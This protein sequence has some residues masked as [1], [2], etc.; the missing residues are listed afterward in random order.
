MKATP[1][2][3]LNRKILFA[4]LLVAFFFC[5]RVSAVK[6]DTGITST[7]I[8]TNG[9]GNGKGQ[10]IGSDGFSRFVFVDDD[11][12][13][14]DL[15]YVRC[16]DA[17]CTNPVKTTVQSGVG[18]MYPGS[19][20]L[21]LGPDGFARILYVKSGYSL[22][23]YTCHD[24]DCS[25]TGPTATT[26]HQIADGTNRPGYYGAEITIGPDGFPRIAYYDGAYNS[27]NANH[28]VRCSDAECASFVDT[29]VGGEN[30]WRFAG[31]SLTM[32]SDGYARI[33]YPQSDNT[34][35]YVRCTDQDC[36]TSPVITQIANNPGDRGVVV[37]MGSDGFARIVYLN[38]DNTLH[39]V[40]CFNDDC[41][42][43]SD[44]MVTT[45]AS[46]NVMDGVGLTIRTGDFA[47][48]AY[49]GFINPHYLHLVTCTNITCSTSHNLIVDTG[50]N[51]GTYYATATGVS[52][53][54]DSDNFPRIL[55][56]DYDTGLR[57]THFTLSDPI[58]TPAINTD[59]FTNVTTTSATLNA[60]LTSDGGE[61]PTV[62][63]KWGTQPDSYPNSCTPVIN[64][65]SAYSRDISGLT[66]STTYHVRAS[67]TNSSGTGNG[68]VQAIIPGIASTSITTGAT[69]GGMGQVIGSDG[70]SRFVFNDQ[71]SATDLTYVRC[72]DAD[73]TNPVMN[74]IESDAGDPY[75]GSYLLTLGPDGFA[76]IIY[77][78]SDDSLWVYTCHD[79][80][81]SPTGPT[82]T[83]SHQIA[84]G[85]NRPGNYGMEISTGLD[86]F[87]RIAYAD[88]HNG[89][90]NHFVRCAD[91]ECENF[92]DT[93]VG[94]ENTS[95]MATISLA[96]GLDG[97]AR[98]VYSNTIGTLDYVKCTDPDCAIS[99]VITPVANGDADN[100]AGWDGVA[101]RIGSDGYARILYENMDYYG[102][103]DGKS[104]I[105]YVTCSDANC[106]SPTDVMVSNN[107][108]ESMLGFA[109]R[110]GNLA[111]IS[112][113]SLNKGWD[114]PSSD[115]IA[116]II[117]C[118]NS[119]CSI[120]SDITAD[121]TYGDFAT[122]AGGSLVVDSNN[123][124]RIVYSPAPG[125]AKTLAFRRR[126]QH[127]I[128]AS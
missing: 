6:A 56:S 82:A 24:E 90:A 43:P 44:V 1:V 53:V 84:D 116:H 33:V 109:I 117:N 50:Y 103:N 79:E 95:G 108:T 93:V 128:L 120:A 34:V 123:F 39:Y 94:G 122:D 110:S 88:D 35:E 104:M 87:P 127:G 64:I 36:A 99:P 125:W 51:N 19:Y 96:M 58:T 3:F 20:I 71:Q 23:V 102:T 75:P 9:T 97:F 25:P 32:G 114:S 66:A 21:T 45:D 22:W 76:R 89:D 101:I 18:T 12:S 111:S 60:T 115:Y 86:G 100:Q 13:S 17:D 26:S 107:A 49:S 113:T 8:T 67:A 37:R 48:I 69:G 11:G 5:M 85:T 15:T 27:G 54:V 38:Q 72:T 40:T 74:V 52:L 47:T 2:R 46:R 29:V 4:L 112:Y 81:C 78:K 73:C 80:D 30:T 91:A 68:S 62:E 70:F 105:H 124:P 16:T 121:I 77:T 10:V 42:A 65:G 14:K 106:T 119:D 98:I 126:L 118:A 61:A 59:F 28:F 83:T 41:T 7:S 55:Y 63:L 31:I 57:Y 92:V